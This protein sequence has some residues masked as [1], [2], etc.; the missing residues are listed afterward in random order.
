MLKTAKLYTKQRL[1]I[2][3]R[4]VVC[5]LIRTMIILVFNFTL[6]LTALLSSQLYRIGA[7]QGTMR[8][9]CFYFLFFNMFCY[10]YVPIGDGKSTVGKYGQGNI[11]ETNTKE[12]LLDSKSCE[13]FWDIKTS[14]KLNAQNILRFFNLGLAKFVNTI[15][16]CNVKFESCWKM[17]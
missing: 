8:N 15:V 2:R 17:C 10:G 5:V 3:E 6:I 14:H 12:R 1:L 11:R 7:L 4:A 13:N 16:N 9:E